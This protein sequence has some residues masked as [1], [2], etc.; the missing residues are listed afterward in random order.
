MRCSL[1]YRWALILLAAPALMPAQQP[2]EKKSPEA[3]EESRPRDAPSIAKPEKGPRLKAEEVEGLP[4]KPA[5]VVRAVKVD[6][7]RPCSIPLV[8]VA[9]KANGKVRLLDPPKGPHAIRYLAPPA[10]PCEK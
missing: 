10:P 3:T 2:S 4:D 8:P 5:V 9:P 6:G 7:L 1:G